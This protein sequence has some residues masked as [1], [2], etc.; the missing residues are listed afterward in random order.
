M[1]Y[2]F[3]YDGVADNLLIQDFIVKVRRNN[4]EVWI[5][6]MRSDN[7]FNNNT[8]KQVLSKTGLSKLNV[9][10]CN[11]KPKWEYLKA[12]NADIYID[13]I[14]NEFEIIK[15]NTNTIPLLWV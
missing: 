1:V 7:Y 3:D 11:N 10:Y 12:I 15:N 2:A 4:N 8:L 13:N 14:N 9:V 6:T 5:V